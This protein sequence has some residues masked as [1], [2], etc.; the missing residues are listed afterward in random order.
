MD[1][2]REG[3]PEDPVEGS[4]V[5]LLCDFRG[6]KYPHSP[7]WF[8]L[9]SSTGDYHQLNFADTSFKNEAKM[10]EIVKIS[11]Q[12][13]KGLKKNLHYD[14]IYLDSFSVLLKCMQIF[15]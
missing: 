5:T 7:N 14:K 2:K 9:N 12:P 3:G 13:N 6:Y 11:E 4:N 1:I 10:N 15:R 8:Y